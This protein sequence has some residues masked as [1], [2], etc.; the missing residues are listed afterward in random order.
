ML[1]PFD[2][3]LRRCSDYRSSAFK[4]AHRNGLFQTGKIP[5]SLRITDNDRAGFE[6][7]R[8]ASA[9]REAADRVDDDLEEADPAVG[10]LA[11]VDRVDDDP[12]A[13]DPAA[14][15]PEAA[16]PEASD[17]ALA[18]LSRWLPRRPATR[19]SGAEMIAAVPF[20][21]L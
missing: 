1:P 17:L 20:F 12:A 10:G 9:C 3:R 4:F 7:H 21:L 19:P 8:A 14:V 13:V 15:D 11:A 16:G 18:R 2:I 5:A 6:L